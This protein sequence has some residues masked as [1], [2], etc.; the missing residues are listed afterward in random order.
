MSVKNNANIQQKQ[1]YFYIHVGKSTNMYTCDDFFYHDGCFSEAK[2]FFFNTKPVFV[3]ETL[4]LVPSVPGGSAEFR[5]LVFI[6]ILFKT[7]VFKKNKSNLP[8]D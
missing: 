7:D 1:T 2:V 3:L 6:F 5:T 4:R 8:T